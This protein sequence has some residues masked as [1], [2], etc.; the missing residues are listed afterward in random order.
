[1]DI[2][3]VLHFFAKLKPDALAVV[4]NSTEL[5][6]SQLD[7]NVKR[8]ARLLQINGVDNS[9][10]VCTML[11]SSHDW[12]VTLALHILGA[13]SFS[14]P[15][16]SK[17]DEVLKPDWL[18][19]M[20]VN[21]D[22]PEE[23]TFVIDSNFEN[24]VNQTDKL[25]HGIG[26]SS[27]EFPARYFFTSGTSGA[28]KYLVTTAAKLNAKA[29]SPSV[30]NFI[31]E[32]E[33]LNLMQLGSSMSYWNALQSLIEG[34]T[35]FVS[36]GYDFKLSKLLNKYAIRTV[37]GSPI[38][39]SAMLDS[40]I[41]TGTKPPLLKTVYMSGSQPTKIQ[42]NRIREVLGARIYNAYG[43]TELGFVAVNEILKDSERGGIIS[44]DVKLE[45]VDTDGVILPRGEVGFVRYSKQDM[46]KKYFN[47]EE[48]TN[49]FFKDGFF[50]PGDLG[51]I[52]ELGNLRLAG[53]ANDVINLGGVKIRPE[54]VE[55]I[56]L[57]VPGVT[58]AAAFP[59]IDSKGVRRL[60]LA[61][62]A[63]PGFDLQVLEDSCQKELRAI[64]VAKFVE[65]E[66]IPRN[67][68]GKIPRS[69]LPELIFGSGK[70]HA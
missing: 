62:V 66:I 19:S 38:Q 16:G 41:Q 23:R 1:M 57:R 46:P 42:V 60:A 70:D 63:E 5:T 30:R 51:F 31:G 54:S 3:G 32:R 22:F 36:S 7:S 6:F 61:Y 18:I 44:P 69:K 14:K 47:S 15:V 2:F 9:N 40:L 11:P 33:F 64:S 48:A 10:L 26:F 68:N 4:T 37:A 21:S 17:L 25:K 35:Y 59:L 56:A 58:D 13:S 27:P 53:R 20:R 49:E 12:Q 24:A 34:R 52:N 28:P 55:E 50:Y 45:I 67:E 29:L 39:I 43:S 65:V 8:I